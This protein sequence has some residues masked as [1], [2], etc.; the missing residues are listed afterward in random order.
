MSRTIQIDHIEDGMILANSILN[1]YGQIILAKD[2]KLE[3]KHIKM[4][5]LWGIQ[6]LE[7][8]DDS[9]QESFVYSQEAIEKANQIV[10]GMI[11]WQPVNKHEEELYQIA[12]DHI[13]ETKFST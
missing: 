1:K 11:T 3:S 4:L 9:M 13:L 10:K 2:A 7:I 6:T 8:V 5:K 12:L